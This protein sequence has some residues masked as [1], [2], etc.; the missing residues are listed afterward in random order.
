MRLRQHRPTVAA[1]RWQ[2][3]KNFASPDL[4]QRS[5]LSLAD[6]HLRMGD[7]GK[8]LELYDELVR[9]FPAGEH[10]LEAH[11]SS[12]RIHEGNG[13]TRRALQAYETA[14][15]A[16]PEDVRAPEIRLQLD[17]LRQD[18]DGGRRG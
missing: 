8:A 16:F 12:A 14:L 9:L 17:R 18:A 4:R 10:A 2:A 11:L 7:G 3:T 13:K 5:I 1:E 15:L 6:Y